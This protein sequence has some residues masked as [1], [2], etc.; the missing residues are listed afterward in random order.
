MKMIDGLC[1]RNMVD[2]AVRNLN[3]HVKLVNQLNVF[4][5]PDGDTGTNMVTTI[6]K[7]LSSVDET[8]V[9]LP[10]VSKKFAR[11]V[12]FEARGNSGVIVSQFL[13]GISEKFYDADA[14]DSELFVKALEKGVL[15]AYSS[16]AAPVEGTM[17]TVMKD[18]TNAVKQEYNQQQSISDVINGFVIHAK[19]SL[20]NTPEL[21]PV[22]KD[23]GVVDSGGAGIVYLFEGMKKYLDGEPLDTFEDNLAVP[24]VDYDSFSTDSKFEFGYC[25]ELLVQLLN[26][27]EA[28]DYDT[29]K[30]ELSSFGNSLVISQEKDKVR[31]HIHTH[32]PEK[33]FALCHKYGEFLSSKIENMT[34]QHTELTKRIIC[35]ESKNNGVFSIVAVA[36]DPEIQKLF[37]N[38]G[39][40]VVICCHESVSTKDYL[41]AFDKTETENIFVFPNSSDAILSAMQAKKLYQKA[42]VYVL[43]SRTVAECYSALPAIDFEETNIEKVSDDITEIIN[44]LYVVSIARRKNSIRYGNQDIY[45]NEYYSFSGKELIVIN[46]S[47]TQTAVKTIKKIVKSKEKEIVTVFYRSSVSEEKVNAIVELAEKQ[48]VC[49]EF[50]IVYTENLP[51]ELTISFE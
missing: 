23:S 42:K 35:S 38:M 20:E 27:K 39:A 29:F 34:V 37:L 30:S 22:L 19:K 3:M 43:N 21:L 49:A 8:I 5:V 48:G 7:G 12:V 36:F 9:D 40:D 11:S 1:F 25:T 10:S 41:D 2:Y 15:Y 4:P 18:A 14:A 24:S 47:L 50:F 28:F 6:H 32:F 51:C 13:K 26:V 45:Q 16:V 33:V 46:E 31:V 44:N 17:L